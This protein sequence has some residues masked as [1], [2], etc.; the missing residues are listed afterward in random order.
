MISV[1]CIQFASVADNSMALPMCLA[2]SCNQPVILHTYFI[3]ALSAKSQGHSHGKGRTINH[4][5]FIRG[6][7]DNPHVY[8][9]IA[10]EHIV[11]FGHILI[12]LARAYRRR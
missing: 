1:G 10:A 9:L 8:L 5:S 6:K 11:S 2:E 4:L 7:M 3:E 12:P